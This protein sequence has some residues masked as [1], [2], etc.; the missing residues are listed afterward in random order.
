MTTATYDETIDITL[1]LTGEQK[2]ILRAW[3]VALESDKFAQVEGKLSGPL[4][5]SDEGDG[6]VVGYCC[7]GVAACVMRDQFPDALAERYV[8]VEIDDLNGMRLHWVEPGRLAV[9]EGNTLTDNLD[10]L[11]G[12][13]DAVLGLDSDNFTNAND[14][15][16]IPFKAIARAIR[17][18]LVGETKEAKAVLRDNEKWADIDTNG[19]ALS[20]WVL[21]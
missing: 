6:Y 21:D 3:V 8:T 4:P 10:T 12:F 14:T 18:A 20:E 11:L 1:D 5:D 17:L 19:Q 16:H 13:G 7:L 2:E 15:Y 9:Q